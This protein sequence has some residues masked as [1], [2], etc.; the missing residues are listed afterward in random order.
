[1]FNIAEHSKATVL[2]NE[3]TDNELFHSPGIPDSL[4]LKHNN[5]LENIAV[6]NKLIKEEIQK[7]SPDN[8]KTELWKDALFD[9]KRQ[10]E[11]VESEINIQFPQY[12]D[13]L[14]KIEPK[15]LETIQSHLKKDETLIEYFLS[16]QYY[17]GK[18]TLY[19]FTVTKGSLNLSEAYLDSLFINDVV[20]IKQVT[21][22]IHSRSN[23]LN[24]YKNFTG[25]LYNMY[26]K[27]VKPVEHLFT[28]A[29]I[30]VIPDEE[31]AY[32]PFDAFIKRNTELS[33]IDYEGLQYLIYNYSFSYGYS[34]S[35]LFARY[36]NRIKG[37]KVYAFSP[38]CRKIS[39]N[40][41]GE[42]GYLAGS[43]KEIN[44]IFKRFSGTKYLGNKATESNFKTII[45]RPAILHLAMHS[46]TDPD[47]SNYSC[48][49][50]DTRSDTINDG[51]LYNY[52]ISLSRIKSPMVVLSACN[53]GS[54]TLYHGEG[55]MSLAR[56]FILAGAS[57][58]IKT[59]WDVNDDA[60]AQIISDF[61]YYLSKGKEKDDALRLAKLKYIK[62]S[63]PTYVNPCYWA[64]YEVMGDKASVVKNNTG[65]FFTIAGAMTV[66]LAGV[67]IC[68]FK[69][70][71]S[72]F[73]RV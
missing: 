23:S 44:G 1:M 58:V 5:L 22:Q 9:M 3:I 18:R 57:S 33:Q 56:G 29:K 62:N 7:I 42:S 35:L 66:L 63:P 71:R 26:N 20:T 64:A 27:L 17:D 41:S 55:I 36:E 54:G 11:K 47:N 70:R 12:H 38:D 32:L 30:I 67:M 46:M 40:S 39:I 59:F 48:L 37:K 53:T 21:G 25:A 50:F 45:K 4:K 14:Q 52:E 10:N 34:S 19:I 51:K 72:F 49:M 73:A 24:D 6:Y 68:Y 61:Y 13:L 43:E 65:L 31:I 16:N 2:K 69:R 8:K 15:N 60:S 28:G